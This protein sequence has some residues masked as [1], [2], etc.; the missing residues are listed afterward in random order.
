MFDAR[1][2]GYLLAAADVFAGAEESVAMQG[3]TF[4]AEARKYARSY[5]I[6]KNSIG[7]ADVGLRETKHDISRYKTAA[8]EEGV[9]PSE[10]KKEHEYVALLNE[11][12]AYRNN[13]NTLKQG[14]A[15][16][17]QGVNECL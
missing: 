16:Y 10:L 2:T 13:W 5:N 17:T 9:T 15:R 4:L 8:A 1:T 14:L 6:I 3:Q 12:A 7:F 11:Y